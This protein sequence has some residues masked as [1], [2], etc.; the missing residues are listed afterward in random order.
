MADVFT[1]KHRMVVS[2]KIIAEYED[3]LHRPQ[4]KLDTLKV[5]KSLS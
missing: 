1:G 4:L 3:V 5:E 2:T